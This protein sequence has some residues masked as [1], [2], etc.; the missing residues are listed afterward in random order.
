MLAFFSSQP[1]RC[2]ISNPKASF[3]NDQRAILWGLSEIFDAYLVLLQSALTLELDTSKRDCKTTITNE[4]VS[5]SFYTLTFFFLML[6]KTLEKQLGSLLAAFSSCTTICQFFWPWT[7]MRWSRLWCFSVS[8]A[9]AKLAKV[10]SITQAW[11]YILSSRGT[12]FLWVSLD[13][14]IEKSG[15]NS[16]A[17]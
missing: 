1:A 5:H 2:T 11:N 12:I 14:V 17:W 7:A 10:L 16:N 9:R 8:P 13:H 4:T 6:F 15:R 3:E